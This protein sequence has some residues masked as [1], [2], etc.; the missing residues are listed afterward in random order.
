MISYR[1]FAGIS[2]VRVCHPHCG[3]VCFVLTFLSAQDC[4]KFV[5]G[6]QV[7]GE[8]EYYHR[9]GSSI[10]LLVVST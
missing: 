2:D 10:F 8:T 3:E 7:D 5:A 4:E 1:S 6:P 9:V